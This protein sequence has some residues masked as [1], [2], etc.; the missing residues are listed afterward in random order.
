M[1][2]SSSSA[3]PEATEPFP[4]D[5]KRIHVTLTSIRTQGDRNDEMFRIYG[6]K[7]NKKHDSKK[8]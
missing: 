2:T 7:V 8:K 3:P 5:K 1:A 6:L 4:K